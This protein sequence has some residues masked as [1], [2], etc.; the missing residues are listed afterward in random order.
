[1]KRTLAVLELWQIKRFLLLCFVGGCALA[2]TS[3]WAAGD[4]ERCSTNSESRQLD[5]WVGDWTVTYPG[6]V[7]SATSKVSLA[8]DQCLLTETW[9]GGTGHSGKNMFAYSADDKNWHGMFADSQGRVHVF[10]GRVV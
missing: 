9:D 6:M 5:F 8:L 10:E 4:A 3:A 1:M 2:A 7:G